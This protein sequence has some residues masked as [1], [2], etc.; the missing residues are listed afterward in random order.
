MTTD[1]SKFDHWIE[2]W[3]YFYDIE[4]Q[5]VSLD[6]NAVLISSVNEKGV[7]NAR[8]VLVKDVSDNGFVFYTNYDSQKGKE[9]FHNSY[10]HLTWY[11]RLQGVSIRAQGKI[12]KVDPTISDLSLI[13]I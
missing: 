7:P 13:H 4:L 1:I 10:G 2:A 6:P 11:S 8:V 3:K 12:E 5:Q 9:L